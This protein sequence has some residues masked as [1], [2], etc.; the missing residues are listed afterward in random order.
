MHRLGVRSASALFAIGVAYAVVVAIGMRMSG[1]SRP[2][3]DPVLAIMEILTLVSAPI[4]V[5]LLIAVHSAAST[6]DKAYAIAALAFMALAAGLTSAVHF[7]GLTALRQSGSGVIVWPSV[8]YAVELLAWDVFLGLSLLFASR[9]FHGG[10]VKRAIRVGCVAT[11]AL[12]LLGTLGPATGNMRFQFIGVAG[13]GLGL[14]VV[15]LLL[16]WDFNRAS[17]GGGEPAV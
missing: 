5:L 7:V 2:I 9:T 11:G 17:A 1:F 13:Y 8:Q 3:A 14:P 4:L 10:G 15:S 16:A 12:C 6:G